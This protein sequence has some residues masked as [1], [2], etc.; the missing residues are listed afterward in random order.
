MSAWS[1]PYLTVHDASGARVAWQLPDPLPW[2]AGATFDADLRTP[3]PLGL[4]AGGT[5]K[6]RWRT[7]EHTNGRQPYD[8]G[9]EPAG[10]A[11][12]D[13]WTVRG[14]STIRRWPIGSRGGRSAT[15]NR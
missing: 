13:S 7:P 14:G 9:V 6:V 15:C 12:T 2:A 1:K 11:A 5:V 4:P 8:S 10:R 3:V